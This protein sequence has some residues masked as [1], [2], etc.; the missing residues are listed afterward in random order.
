MNDP[1][2]DDE[3]ILVRPF[4]AGAARFGT[5]PEAP[6]AEDDSEVRP[7]VITRGRATAGAG[8]PWETLVVATHLG[9]Q[10]RASFEAAQI[11]RLCERTQSVAEVSAHLRLPIG[12]VRV[13]VADLVGDGLLEAS[14]PTTRRP[15]DDVDFLERLMHGVAAL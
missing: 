2:H 11:L 15:A 12:V 6:A 9:R 13:L 3:E 10:V 1:D 7:Y 14:T 8:L 4:L 5:R